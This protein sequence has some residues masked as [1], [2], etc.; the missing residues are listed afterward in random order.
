M[1]KLHMDNRTQLAVYGVHEGYTV[2]GRA[3]NPTLGHSKKQA[4]ARSR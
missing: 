1:Q 2:N 3:G 4:D